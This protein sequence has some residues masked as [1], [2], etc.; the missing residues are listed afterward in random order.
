MH[1]PDMAKL[2]QLL[3]QRGRWNDRQVISET[4]VRAAT[5]AR[6]KQ[7]SHRDHY[8]YFWWVKGTDFPGMFE[9]VGRGGQR[10]NVWPAKDLVLVFTGGG[11]EPGDLAPFILKALQSDV[12]LT[13]N[14]AAMAR[15]K[16]RMRTATQAPAPKQVGKLPDIAARVSGRRYALSSNGLDLSEMTLRFSAPSA[17]AV[18]LVRQGTELRS[19]VGL[20]D[21]ERFSTDDLLGLPFA[22]KGGWL[23]DDTFLLQIDRVGGINRYD[24]R[25]TFSSDAK[26]VKISLKEHTG[27]NNESFTGAVIP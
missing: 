5:R 13:A 25:F 2:G 27:L 10:I 19:P 21:V 7:T 4:W 26:T 23:G 17:A 12:S 8:G 18:R 22:A 24:F 9:A 11:F 1:P 6:V 16:D 14:P 20:D 15:L 3:L